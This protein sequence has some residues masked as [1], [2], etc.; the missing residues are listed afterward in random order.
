MPRPITRLLAEMQTSIMAAALP[1]M[2]GNVERFGIY[3]LVLRQSLRGAD[4][5]T[6]VLSLSSSLGLPFET[7]RR[8]VQSLIAMGLCER[9]AG[10]IV[11]TDRWHRDPDMLALTELSHDCFVRFIEDLQAAAP[12]PLQERLS[13]TYEWTSG[14]Q[15]A[16]DLMLAVAETNRPAH[17]DWLDLVLFSTVL[18][19]DHRATDDGSFASAA[20]PLRSIRVAELARILSLAGSTVQRRVARLI[21]AGVLENRYGG[22]VISSAWLAQDLAH[23]TAGQTQLNLRRVLA[24]LTAKGFP[25]AEPALAYRNGRPPAADLGLRA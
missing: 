16:I 5:G 15:A 22:I 25:F 24:A 4:S 6:P 11:A 20:T 9:I 23:E 17:P 14:V 18:C 21:A 12:L 7:T 19:A 8:H 2:N 13:S 1:I 3:V 10:G